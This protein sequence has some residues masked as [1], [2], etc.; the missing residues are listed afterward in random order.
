VRIPKAPI[1]RLIW[2]HVF[3]IAVAT[4]IIWVGIYKT[5]GCWRPQIAMWDENT[6]KHRESNLEWFTTSWSLIIEIVDFS[7]DVLLSIRVSQ[8]P[9]LDVSYT[10][11]SLGI[12]STVVTFDLF[13]IYR[14]CCILTE[15]RNDSV[16]PEGWLGQQGELFR[17]A[18]R[19]YENQLL[20]IYTTFLEDIPSV[21]LTS[22]LIVKEKRDDIILLTCAISILCLGQKLA[23]IEKLFMWKSIGMGQHTI[24]ENKGR[25]VREKTLTDFLSLVEQDERNL[26]RMTVSSA[27]RKDTQPE[28]MM[29]MNSNEYDDDDIE[30][31]EDY[32]YQDFHFNSNSSCRD[33]Y[34]QSTNKMCPAQLA[35]REALIPQGLL[36]ATLR[37]SPI[38]PPN[39]VQYPR[40]LRRRDSRRNSFCFRSNP[41]KRDPM[42]ALRSRR[43]SLPHGSLDP[44]RRLP[45]KKPYPF[46]IAES[47]EGEVRKDMDK[48]KRKH[49]K[50]TWSDE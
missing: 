37:S 34:P 4:T 43:M 6:K 22:V 9:A 30:F 12:L 1:E 39:S 3:S 28:L 32:D 25:R 18:R 2:W 15:V 35:A 11:F 29:S 41:A 21:I 27:F 31:D 36:D 7:S 17:R 33:L 16:V 46:P 20:T 44:S 50:V 13:L 10:I 45:P 47:E 23:A 40:T 48:T 38:K 26:R 5:W 14:R 49:K 19:G 42:A 8:D 24:E